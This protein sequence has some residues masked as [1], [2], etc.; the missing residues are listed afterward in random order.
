MPS[1]SK[2]FRE[3]TENKTTVFK[4]DL[5]VKVTH[6]SFLKSLGMFERTLRVCL[7]LRFEFVTLICV[8]SAAVRGCF[9]HWIWLT[10]QP[11]ALCAVC[12]TLR[13][14]PV[15]V[16]PLCPAFALA[17]RRGPRPLRAYPRNSLSDL[18]FLRVKFCL[19]TCSSPV[20][21]CQLSPTLPFARQFCGNY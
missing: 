11:L 4:A 5:G 8:R 2:G 10:L 15:A 18:R 3:C 1:A 19:Q 13:L 17:L 14:C 16:S 20:L 12:S 7:L 9:W 21:R 6:R